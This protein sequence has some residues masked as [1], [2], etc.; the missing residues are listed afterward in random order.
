M[1]ANEERRSDEDKFIMQQ[2][3]ITGYSDDES[4]EENTKES[5]SV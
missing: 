2:Y 3:G 5:G 1:N 4:E